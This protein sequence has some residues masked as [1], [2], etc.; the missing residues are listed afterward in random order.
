MSHS[1]TWQAH[2]DKG[3]DKYCWYCENP[4]RGSTAWRLF[5]RSVPGRL[6]I[7]KAAMRAAKRLKVK[8]LKRLQGKKVSP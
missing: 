8:I 2:R 3:C 6:K 5:A 4:Q 1:S 7:G